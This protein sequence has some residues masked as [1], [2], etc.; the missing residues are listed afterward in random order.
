MKHAV[1]IIP[2]I[3]PHDY[4]ELE[5]KIDL[6]KSLVKTVQIDV[7]DGQLTPT[8]T[9]PY[10]K[11]D[12]NFEEI[13]REEKGLP[14][15]QD[16]AFEIDLLL[17]KPEEVINDWITAGAE[18]IIVHH[19]AQPDYAQIIDMCTGRVDIGIAVVPDTDPHV[20]AP[21]V[22]ALSVVQCMG[23]AHI[24]AQGT[25]IDPAIY[26]YI[27]RMR[28]YLPEHVRIAIDIGVTIE[29]AHK[30]IEAGADTLIAGS[31]IFGSVNIVDT[32]AKF[33]RL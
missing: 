15:W 4:A 10:K 29:N 11:H 14:Y 32:L 30:L 33:K 6:V 16:V 13:V 7:C 26:E 3:L 20:L 31:A 19:S 22:H 12:E 17:K 2:A 1:R 25:P 27:A 8:A 28:N 24:G 9:W 5:H 18:R 23:S 21:Y